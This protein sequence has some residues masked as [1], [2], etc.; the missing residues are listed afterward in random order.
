MK[1][2]RIKEL[3]LVVLVAVFVFG[4]I[5]FARAT[6]EW[7][8][9]YE[10]PNGHDLAKALTID[11][12]G[13]TYVTG[14]SENFDAGN[15]YIT[16]KYDPFGNELWV[17]RYNGPANDYDSAE[18]ISVDSAGN[19]YVTGSSR[20][21][22]TS[23][24]YATIK[25]DAGGNEE[26]VAR[27]NGPGNVDDSAKA[28][29]I[30][31][32]GNI[33]VTGCS[34]GS[35]ATVK[36]DS[37]G[38]ELWAARYN[39]PASGWAVPSGIVADTFGNVYVT[40]W[41]TV[42]PDRSDYAT[43]K[44]DRSGNELWVARYNGSASSYDNATAIA[45]DINGNVYVT[46]DSTFSL[47]AYGYATIKY[48]P[49]GN[50][51]WVARYDRGIGSGPRAIAVDPSGN[52]HVTGW[53]VD[54]N[55]AMSY[56]ATIKYGTD[57]NQLWEALYNGPNNDAESRAFAL[58]LDTNGS[59]YVAGH[60]EAT[61]TGCNYAAI[62][63]DANGNEQ[64]EE[65]YNGPSN[66]YDSVAALGVDSAGN[67]YVTGRSQG[68]DG[69]YDYAT[70]KYLG[71]STASHGNPICSCELIPD[72]IVVQRGQQLGFAASVT[73]HAGGSGSVLFATKVTK[74][75]ASQTGFIW[76]PLQVWLN[77]RQ[78]K[79]GYKT[80]TVP[81][82]LELGTYTYHGYVGRYG[83]IYHECQFDFEVVQ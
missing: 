18:A 6:H 51:L 82:G 26:W 12:D 61:D 72:T 15:D 34:V 46:G 79:S 54:W 58:A 11:S 73:K 35:Y 80:H 29:A 10:G 7:A 45:V 81:L 47:P 4:D 43:I 63:Y 32:A 16:I 14:C 44:Y 52:V 69:Y 71:D 22:G 49:S 33:Y 31:S 53:S 36:Y 65:L 37:S 57:G 74:P 27:Y 39:A 83:N 60:V 42:S 76:G 1:S 77:P 62:K 50:Q 5:G 9:R 56:F 68:D 66:G 38:N 17:A 48:D 8:A 3:F 41:E 13:N 23:L 64:Q 40:G 25:Y 2:K 67:V 55:M 75:D 70:I 28:L 21:L 19:A 30:D 20:G 78:T 24:D 59:V